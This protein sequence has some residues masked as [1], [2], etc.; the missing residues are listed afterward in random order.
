M[1][2][3]AETGAGEAGSS[4]VEQQYR[5]TLARQRQ[6]P[7]SLPTTRSMVL[8]QDFGHATSTAAIVSAAAS[9]PVVCGST[10]T[11]PI[12]HTLPLVDTSNP[13]SVAKLTA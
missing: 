2:D 10:A 6:M 9:R 5:A 7:G 11:T 13:A 4:T 1:A 12:P 8:A 3:I